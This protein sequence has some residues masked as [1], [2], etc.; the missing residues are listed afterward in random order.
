MTL[1]AVIVELSDDDDD[2]NDSCR[3]DYMC[4]VYMCTHSVYCICIVYIC[5]YVYVQRLLDTLAQ[6]EA[7]VRRR[8][9]EMTRT[10]TVLRVN[11]KILARKYTIAQQVET[12][13][14]QVITPCADIV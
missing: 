1:T 14:R 4:K 2:H 7:E 10:I 12:G 6:D 9:V 8:L 13:L 11:E 5:V 3:L